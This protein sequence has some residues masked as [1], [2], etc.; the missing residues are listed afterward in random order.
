MNE[1][2]AIIAAHNEEM[3]VGQVVKILADSKL[4]QEI[5]VVS[6]GSTDNTARRAREAGAACVCELPFQHGKGLAMKYGV[7][8]SK[9]PFLFFCDADILEISKGLIEKIL[10]PVLSGELAMCVG[11]R[12]RGPFLTPIARHMPLTSGIRAMKREVFEGAP[13][14]YLRGFMVEVALNYFCRTHGLPYGT[15]ICEDF[16]FRRK[17][18]KVGILRGLGGYFVMGYQI[19][20]GLVSVRI[21]RLLGKF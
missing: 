17:I 18:E 3:T 5:I 6:D 2:A 15:V 19:L 20:K 1:V 12:D 10:A 13:E 8:E 11:L 14:K 4:F 16:K 7:L 9:A 21:A